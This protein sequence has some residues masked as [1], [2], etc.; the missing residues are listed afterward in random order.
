LKLKAPIVIGVE[1]F[2]LKGKIASALEK[3]GKLGPIAIGVEV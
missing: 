2:G 3:S 1:L